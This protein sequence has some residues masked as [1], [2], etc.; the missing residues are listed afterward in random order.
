[1]NRNEAYE[2]GVDAYTLG[3][4]YSANPYSIET[5]EF[6]DWNAGWN[7]GFDRFVSTEFR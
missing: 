6:S 1:M 3:V 5:P 2:E 7:Y 4:T